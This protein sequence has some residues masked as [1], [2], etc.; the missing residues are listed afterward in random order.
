MK[1]KL[2]HR[3]FH[4]GFSIVMGALMV[5]VITFVTTLANL[6]LTAGFV[7]SWAKTLLLAYVVAVPGIY[8]LAPLARRIVNVFVQ[9]PGF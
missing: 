4:L 3:F 9:P 8:F 1:E 2:P 7:A 6:G 5:T